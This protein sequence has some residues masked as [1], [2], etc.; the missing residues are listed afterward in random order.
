MTSKEEK[1]ISKGVE[2][3]VI[4]PAFNEEKLIKNTIT[5]VKTFLK[6]NFTKFEIIVVDDSS[7][8]NTLAV[9]EGL[10]NIRVLKN[11]RNHGKGYTVA[12]GM[13]AAS[14]DWLLFM[15]ADNSTKITELKKFLPHRDKYDL[16]IASR[17]LLD[18]DVQIKQNF[19]KSFFGRIGNIFSRLLIDKDIKDTQCGFKL[20]S[21]DAKYLFEKLTIAGFAFDFELIFLAKKYKF[22]TKEIAVTWV[23]NFDSTVKWY[24]Y[25]K[26]MLNL[27][28]IHINNLL[29]KYN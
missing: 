15:D 19:I 12:K 14:G 24:D 27:I 2:I 13:K 16:L 23:N 26:T 4:I 8:D 3:S 10:D 1:I 21:K 25:P 28:L 29:G 6:D 7:T 9:L 20:I 5:E 22:K 17:G 18:S 11:L